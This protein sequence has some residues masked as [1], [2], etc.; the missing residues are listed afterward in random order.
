MQ[1]YLTGP[2]IRRLR[3]AR[4]L[5]QAQLAAQLFVSDKTVSKWETAKG[6]PDISLVEPLAAALDVSVMELMSGAPVV[7]RN[8]AANLLR[9]RFYVCPVCGNILHATGDAVLSCCGIALPAL[10]AE[11]D[12]D[13]ILS[14]VPVEDEVCV[15]ARHPMEK[16]HDLSFLAHETADALHL[17]KLYPEGCAEVRFRLR[18]RG[19]LYAY[20]NRHGLI[21]VPIAP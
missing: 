16:S 20:C 7:N 1:T 2:V 13:G 3:E 12:T 5:T 11:P 18:R 21:G 10:E 17:V 9:A 15:T 4:G 19:M 8:V 14:V 6:L